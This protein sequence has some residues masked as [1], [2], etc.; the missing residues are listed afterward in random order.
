MF[1]STPSD[2]QKSVIV[3]ILRFNIYSKGPV[4]AYCTVLMPTWLTGAT[5]DGKQKVN[6]LD[7][8]VWNQTGAVAMDYWAQDDNNIP[9]AYFENV[10]DGG[11]YFWHQLDFNQSTYI[12]AEPDA[13][14][15]DIPDN[16]HQKCNN[17]LPTN[18]N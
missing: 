18:H 15:F 1:S 7:C 14:I 17:T 2:C 8:N 6:G 11:G 13:S 5:Y 12:I 3:Y 4:G 16:C 9:C 10:T